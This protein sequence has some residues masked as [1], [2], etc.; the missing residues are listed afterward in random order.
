[1]A[2][3]WN[4][5]TTFLFQKLSI[6]ILW[7]PV[8]ISRDRSNDWWIIYQLV[9]IRLQSGFLLPWLKFRINIINYYI[10][11]NSWQVDCETNIVSLCGL[12]IYVSPIILYIIVSIMPNITTI[13]NDEMM[14][15][16]QQSIYKCHHVSWRCHHAIY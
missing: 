16:N 1:M 4:T 8:I 14:K 12:I 9:L 5:D 2:N 10:I 15:F 11:I 6:S 13:M 3:G 7:M